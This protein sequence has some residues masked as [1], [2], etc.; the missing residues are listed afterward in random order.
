[1]SAESGRPP[2][3]TGPLQHVGV[4]STAPIVLGMKLC[5]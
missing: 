4:D 3:L 2:A 1:M 5:W